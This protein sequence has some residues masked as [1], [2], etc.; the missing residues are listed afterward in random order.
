LKEAIEAWENALLFNPD[1]ETA[2]RNLERARKE[3]KK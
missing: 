3:I 2:Q 1:L